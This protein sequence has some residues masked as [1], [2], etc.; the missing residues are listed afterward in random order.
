MFPCNALNICNSL[1]SCDKPVDPLSG[2]RHKT[3]TNTVTCGKKC[4]HKGKVQRGTGDTCTERKP[5]TGDSILKEN[6]GDTHTFFCEQGVSN[7]AGN[8]QTHNVCESE[9][10]SENTLCTSDDFNCTS[11]DAIK[12]LNQ[13]YERCVRG[14]CIEQAEAALQRLREALS[15][16]DWGKPNSAAQAR[17]LESHAEPSNTEFMVSEIPILD[18]LLSYRTELGSKVE[19]CRESCLAELTDIGDRLKQR[20]LLDYHHDFD[21]ILSRFRFKEAVEYMSFQGQD[22]SD[23]GS[24]D[25]QGSYN[26]TKMSLSSPMLRDDGK[27]DVAGMWTNYVLSKQ[28][29]EA[30]VSCRVIL[31]TILSTYRETVHDVVTEKW[32]S[33]T[34]LLETC[35][36]II[37]TM[38]TTKDMLQKNLTCGICLDT[39]TD[40]RTFKFLI[41]III[42][43]LND[44][45]TNKSLQAHFDVGI[46]FARSAF[47]SKKITLCSNFY[48]VAL[49]ADNPCATIATMSIKF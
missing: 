20:L 19:K 22:E 37:Q 23:T 46:P 6:G 15:A 4:S 26:P 35:I 31:D 42:I 18:K 47:C 14:F 10:F 17:N 11:D 36:V 39:L 38:H 33:Q 8:D 34:F 13:V 27:I 24:T 21:V 12:M 30:F 48:C 40:P 28:L 3:S 25:T 49:S 1:H 45:S 32:K 2:K 16:I 44:L 7:Q 43:T 41:A 29:S 9:K 5:S